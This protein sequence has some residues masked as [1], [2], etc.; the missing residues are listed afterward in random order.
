MVFFPLAV[1]HSFS[2]SHKCTNLKSHTH[3]HTQTLQMLRDDICGSLNGI[4]CQQT[5]LLNSLGVCVRVC[6]FVHC[7]EEL[8]RSG[9][10]G[11]SISLAGR[12][13]E[14]RI[15]LQVCW[16]SFAESNPRAQLMP[17]QWWSTA[18]QKIMIQPFC[19]CV[20]LTHAFSQ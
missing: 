16:A 7:S 15:M 1:F 3:R 17:A 11:S 4:V 8:M 6:L 14:Y 5:S 12:T 13:M 2:S 18:G 20:D 9:R 10:S 19:S